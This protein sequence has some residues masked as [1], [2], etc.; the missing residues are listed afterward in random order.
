M[1]VGGVQRWVMQMTR[2]VERLDNY[3]V[4]KNNRIGWVMQMTRGVERLDNYNVGKN[5]RIGQAI[6]DIYCMKSLITEQ[7]LSEVRRHLC[8]FL[9]IMKNTLGHREDIVSIEFTDFHYRQLVLEAGPEPQVCCPHPELKFTNYP[10]VICTRRKPG[11]GSVRKREVTARVDQ[12]IDQLTQIVGALVNTFQN[13]VTNNRGNQP[14][15][16]N[17][18]DLVGGNGANECQETHTVGIRETAGRRLKISGSRTHTRGF[19]GSRQMRPVG[20]PKK[21]KPQQMEVTIKAHRDVSYLGTEGTLSAS[22][23]PLPDKFTAPQF[24]LYE[25]RI[26]PDDHLELYIGHMVFH[27]YPEEIMCRAFRNTLSEAARQWFMKLQPN[28]IPNWEDW[29]IAFSNQFLGVVATKEILDKEAS[30]GAM[31][32]MRHDI[33]FRDDLLQKPAKIYQEFLERAQEFIN[34]KEAKSVTTRLT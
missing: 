22:E 25:G 19:M 1:M 27:G 15:P 30:M 16:S 3:N 9:N 14:Q 23:V 2:G 26:D 4:G 28:Y 6:K 18:I 20:E 21:G 32:S 12:R 24:I 5:N 8:T 11:D 31:S 17:P 13:W 29:K 7:R 10:H 33:P 34:F